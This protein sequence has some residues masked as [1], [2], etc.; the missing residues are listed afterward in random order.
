MEPINSITTYI[1]TKANL[2]YQ[3]KLA[4]ITQNFVQ[5][6]M[7]GFLIMVCLLVWYLPVIPIG[8]GHNP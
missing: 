5:D 2:N 8:M 6:G 7:N 4:K 1:Y 3:S